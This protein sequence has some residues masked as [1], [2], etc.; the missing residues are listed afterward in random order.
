M[1]TP[2]GEHG[3]GDS[4]LVQM[5]VSMSGAG[6]AEHET[7]PPGADEK[8]FKAGH[9]PDRFEIRGILYVPA[10]V[11]VVLVFTYAFVQVTFHWIRNPAPPAAANPQ[12]KELNALDFN[13]RVGRISSTDPE[14]VLERPGTAVPQPRLEFMQEQA[15]GGPDDPPFFR[16]KRA[17]QERNSPEVRPQDLRPGNYVDPATGQKPLADWAFTDGKKDAIRVPI[18]EAIHMVEHGQIK[19]PVRKDPVNPGRTT[20]SAAKASNGG[21]A[22]AVSAPVTVEAPKDVPHKH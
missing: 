12:V 18:D 7:T 14:P 3:K 9:E 11:A 19:L 8:S 2:H 4:P 5:M 17:M 21:N 6:A 22:A 16:S 10:L 13:P 15:G 20:E 1:S